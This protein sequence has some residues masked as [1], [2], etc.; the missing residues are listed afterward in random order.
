MPTLE[1]MNYRP[2]AVAF[3]EQT[4]CKRCSKCSF[5]WLCFESGDIVC[6]GGICDRYEKEV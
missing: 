4:G 1:E 5:G 2:N 3:N 6:S